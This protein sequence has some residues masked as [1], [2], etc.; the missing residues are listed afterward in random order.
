MGIKKK[1]RFAS[2]DFNSCFHEVYTFTVYQMNQQ[3]MHP[4]GVEVLIW[5]DELKNEKFKEYPKHF[6]IEL[7]KNNISLESVESELLTLP[8]FNDAV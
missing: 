7:H 8:Y 5:V 2:V 1:L 4:V 6:G 3:G